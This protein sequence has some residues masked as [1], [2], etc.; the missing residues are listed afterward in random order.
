[1]YAYARERNSDTHIKQYGYK[2]TTK[3]VNKKNTINVNTAFCLTTG[4][5]PK[6]RKIFGFLLTYYYLCSINN[7]ARLWLRKDYS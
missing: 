2:D 4:R 1:M 3:F 5:M 7:N 6:K